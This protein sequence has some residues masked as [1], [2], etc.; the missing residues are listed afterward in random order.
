MTSTGS[1]VRRSRWISIVAMTLVVGVALSLVGTTGS[2]RPAAATVA[3]PPDDEAAFIGLLNQARQSSGLATLVTDPAAASVARAWAAQMGS[4]NTLH[5][6][7]SLAAQVD[8]HVTSAWARIGENVGVGYSVQS[9]HDALWA[10]P[11]HR[12]NLLGDYNRVGVGVV[13]AGGRIWVTQV[14]VKG[15]AIAPPAPAASGGSSPLGGLDLVHQLPG[16]VRVAGWSLDPDTAASNDVHVYVDSAGVSVRAD[17][18]RGDIANAFP[19]YGAAHGFDVTVPMG[20]G[21]HNVCAYGINAAGGGGNTLL[22]CRFVQLGSVPFGSVD[23]VWW[24]AGTLTV[25]GWAVDSVTDASIDVHVYIDGVGISARADQSRSDVAAAVPG[26]GPAHGFAV[27]TPM[28]GG[29]HSVCVFGI[30]RVGNSLLNCRDIELP[31]TPIGALDLVY[32]V[33]GGVA[34]SGWAFDPET[35]QSIDVHLWAGPVGVSVPANGSRSDVGGAFPGIGD[36]H[37]FSATI[38]LGPGPA[39]IC[40]FAIGVGSGGNALLGCRTV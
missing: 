1:P 6:N 38:G 39:E 11:G 21:G 14:F 30:G 16:A 37:G 10:S 19:G 32:R 8:A 4:E 24:S 33:P 34:V 31:A 22:G 12:A 26:Y 5:H 36:R 7:P 13:Y 25:G 20:P 35:V 18:G 40:A 29:R 27:T 15:P 9:L 3:A 23:G 28:A 2:A 17:R